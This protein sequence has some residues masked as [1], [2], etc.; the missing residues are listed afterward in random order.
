VR[1]DYA[2]PVRGVELLADGTLMLIGVPTD[3]ITVVD[4]PEPVLV[5]VVV[6]VSSSLADSPG[7][8]VLEARV[9]DN[10]LEQIGEEMRLNFEMGPSPDSPPGWDLKTQFPL[11][12]HWLA[13]EYGTYSIELAVDSTS[14]SLP[15][16]V[17]PR[18]RFDD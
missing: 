16:I 10:E 17:V 2:I 4:P 13:S 11:G 18:E 15:I 3:T 12:F 9:L 6:G 8:H 5:R 7:R 1:I 14:A